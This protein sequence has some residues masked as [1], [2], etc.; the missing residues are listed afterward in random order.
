MLL[1]LLLGCLEDKA[2][3]EGK[4]EKQELA[5]TGFNR[6]KGPERRRR[7]HWDKKTSSWDHW[8]ASCR[9]D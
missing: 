4:E 6:L 9:F 2:F 8:I 3:R 5:G 7:W 1:F